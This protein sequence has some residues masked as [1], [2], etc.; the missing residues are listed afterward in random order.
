MITM[1]VNYNILSGTTSCIAPF[2][3]DLLPKFDQYRRCEPNGVVTFVVAVPDDYTD[4]DI[5]MACKDSV[6]SMIGPIA[7]RKYKARGYKTEE[8][9]ICQLKHG[10]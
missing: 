1:M 6:A 10:L 9:E 4:H 5:I 3:I 7:C 2:D 8:D